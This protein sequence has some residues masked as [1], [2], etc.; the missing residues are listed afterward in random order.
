[1]GVWWYLLT[2]GLLFNILI[3]VELVLTWF[4]F[5][6]SFDFG[7]DFAIGGCTWCYFGV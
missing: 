4:E 7:L 3:F 1:M 2:Y 5:V 6:V